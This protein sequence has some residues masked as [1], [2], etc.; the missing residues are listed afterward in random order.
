MKNEITDLLRVKRQACGFNDKW[1]ILTAA[2]KKKYHSVK[3]YC[4][5]RKQNKIPGDC[6]LKARSSM[7][8][9]NEIVSLFIWEALPLRRQQTL[10]WCDL[11]GSAPCLDM[12][13]QE[14]VDTP[15]CGLWGWGRGRQEIFP[16]FIFGRKKR[17]LLPRAQ[18]KPRLDAFLMGSN[19]NNRRSWWWRQVLTQSLV[20]YIHTHIIH[21]SMMGCRIECK[22]LN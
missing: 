3:D 4:K 2:W 13:L 22:W 17:T 11:S 9:Q 10:P 5:R 18:L 21:S 14:I 19:G 1:C 6:V 7:T 15:L 20:I 8:K 16:G 12:D